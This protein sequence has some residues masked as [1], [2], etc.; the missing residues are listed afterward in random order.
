MDE[1]LKEIGQRE[2]RTSIVTAESIKRFIKE[3]YK[4]REYIEHTSRGKFNDIYITTHSKINQGKYEIE[5]PI[6]FMEK[7]IISIVELILK[8]DGVVFESYNE[9]GGSPLI[10]DSNEDMNTYLV[11]VQFR[12]KE[13]I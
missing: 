2:S 5:T 10:L 13:K 11:G 9:G 3:K 8:E 4:P 1:R 6:R 7:D 12:L